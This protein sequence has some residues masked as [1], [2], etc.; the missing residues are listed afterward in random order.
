[1]SALRTTQATLPVFECWTHQGSE[2]DAG[3][4]GVLQSQ[5]DHRGQSEDN[6]LHVLLSSHGTGQL[7]QAVYVATPMRLH[8]GCSPQAAVHHCL[9]EASARWWP[10]HALAVWAV[11]QLQQ[12]PAAVPAGPQV[13]R[14]VD[15][16]DAQ[17]QRLQE[18]SSGQEG[19]RETGHHQFGIGAKCS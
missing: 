19:A 9:A 18:D 4:H 12:G 2:A 5:F 7:A 6:S 8:L 13:V 11:P 3:V 15:D 14:G 17:V 1:M 10:Q 16:L